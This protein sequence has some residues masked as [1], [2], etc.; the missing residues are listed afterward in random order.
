MQSTIPN[1]GLSTSQY[2]ETGATLGKPSP[3]GLFGGVLEKFLL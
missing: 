3:C 2:P 1:M